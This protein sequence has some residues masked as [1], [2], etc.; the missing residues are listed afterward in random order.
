MLKIIKNHFVIGDAVPE[1]TDRAE[2]ADTSSLPSRASNARSSESGGSYDEE[3]DIDTED[4]AE[5]LHSRNSRKRL[6]TSEK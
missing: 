2:I 1:T 4:E 6:R 3:T 5:V